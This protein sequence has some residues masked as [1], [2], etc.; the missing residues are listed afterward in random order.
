MEHKPAHTG[1]AGHI[2]GYFLTGIL[3][4]APIAI[5]AFTVWWFLDLVDGGV[6]RLIPFD[7]ILPPEYLPYA[8]PGVGLL[9]AVL[10]IITVGALTRN[11]LGRLILQAS[12][13]VVNRLPVVNSI[14]GAV[15]QMFESVMT[16]SPSRAFK[17]V[18]LMEF[19]SPGLWSIGF[20]TGPTKGEVARKIGGEELVNIYLPTT[21]IPTTGYLLF[22]P[23]SKLIYLDMTAEEA[24]KM[25]F[26]SGLI[27]PPEGKKSPDP[28]Q[29]DIKVS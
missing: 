11:F 4:T 12:E 10:F 1:V 25:I 13:Y 3:V 21:P 9:L 28:V 17:E 6:R 29:I 18:V 23:K 8:V 26:S 27:T 2:K 15:K 24:I 19:P 20:V 16:T 22:M 5:T 7:R 14:Y